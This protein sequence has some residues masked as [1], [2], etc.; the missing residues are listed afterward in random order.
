MSKELFVVLQGGEF[1][2][3]TTR[4]GQGKQVIVCEMAQKYLLLLS[5]RAV[6]DIN[7]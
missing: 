4:E 1:H 5:I 6:G 2:S 3:F 7:V